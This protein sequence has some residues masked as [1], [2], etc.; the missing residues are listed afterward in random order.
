MIRVNTQDVPERGLAN[1][2]L[3]QLGERDIFGALD[4]VT[5]FVDMEHIGSTMQ[6]TADLQSILCQVT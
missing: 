5:R 1:T 3:T 4:F 2:P 6:H